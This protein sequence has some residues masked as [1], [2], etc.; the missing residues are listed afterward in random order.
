VKTL[1]DQIKARNQACRRWLAV[2]VWMLVIFI[3]STESFSAAKAASIS[4]VLG[5]FL[6]RKLAHLGEYSIL[7]ALIMRARTAGEVNSK[8]LRHLPIAV[9][10][11][12]FYALTDEW[13]QSFVRDRN[14]QISDVAVD[15]IGAV[16]GS[17]VWIW[18]QQIRG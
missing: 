16:W 3:L 12:V 6:V 11:S 1:K 10:I 15:A 5:H 9:T 7:A 18:Y 17:F 14:S 13:H 4:P 2:I 8:M